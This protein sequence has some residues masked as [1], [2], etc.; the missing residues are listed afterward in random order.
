[1]L[2]FIMIRIT[3]MANLFLNSG[4]L[5]FG[6]SSSLPPLVGGCGGL[7]FEYLLKA[8]LLSDHFDGKQS[9]ESVNSHGKP[10]HVIFFFSRP[11]VPKP[12][13]LRSSQLLARTVSCNKKFTKDR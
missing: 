6:S 1:M 5:L 13:P 12:G 7:M 9:R 3:I 11:V 4:Q 10:T 2:L 8:D